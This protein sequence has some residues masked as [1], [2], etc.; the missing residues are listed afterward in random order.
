VWDPTGLPVPWPLNP[1]VV[2]APDVPIAIDKIPGALPGLAGIPTIPAIVWPSFPDLS[3]KWP[4]GMPS[5]VKD[6]LS[7]IESGGSCPEWDWHLVTFGQTFHLPI[8]MCMFDPYMP[9][10]RGLLLVVSTFFMLW[11]MAAAVLGLA[12]LVQNNDTIIEL[13]GDD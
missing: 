8:S 11:A 3:G 13:G 6:Q 10:L 2:P 1:P 9:E 12:T 5:W 7:T 4:F